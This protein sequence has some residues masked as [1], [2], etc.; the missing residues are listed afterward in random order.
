MQN[1][2]K[3]ISQKINLVLKKGGILVALAVLIIIFAI[4]S[5]AFFTVTNL[6]SIIRQ[7]SLL[8]IIAMGMTMVIVCGE[9]DLS[10]GSIY[11]FAAMIG[12]FLMTKGGLPIWL[13]VIIAIMGGVLIGL[14]NGVFVT[15]VKVPSFIVTLGM[16]SIAR[17]VALLITGGLPIALSVRNVADPNLDTYTLMARGSIFQIPF[18]SLF[19]ITIAFISYLVFHKT[20]LGFRMRATGGNSETAKVSGI[21]VNLVKIIA[22]LIVAFMASFAGILNLF[23]LNNIQGTTGQ[24]LELSVIAAVIIGGTSLRGG[25][26]TILNTI[27]GVILIGVLRTGLVMLGFTAF[28]Q[29]VAL[30]G[31]IILAVALDQWVKR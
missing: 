14:I 31:V 11:G 30:G 3:N 16:L 15:Y 10:V 7:G 27:G 25:T 5:P 1:V 9:F 17:G 4:T 20:I 2:L 19:F 12:A 26:G 24:S 23:F 29:M 18:M 13:A 6:L 28:S 8:G 22:F 21:N